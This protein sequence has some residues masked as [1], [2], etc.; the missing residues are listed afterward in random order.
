MHGTNDK[1]SEDARSAYTCVSLYFPTD[2]A[3]RA[4]SR[5]S[6]DGSSRRDEDIRESREFLTAYQSVTAGRAKS[7][8]GDATISESPLK[9]PVLHRG[10]VKGPMRRRQGDEA[11]LISGHVGL[12]IGQLTRE[13]RSYLLVI[14]MSHKFSSLY[15]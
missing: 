10:K 15:R 3:C 13:V 6:S 12:T 2:L 8:Q 9:Q 1:G 4:E 14:I 11:V 7:A 5:C